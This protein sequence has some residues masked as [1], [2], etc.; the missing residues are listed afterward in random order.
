[1]KRFDLGKMFS[2]IAGI[3]ALS[4]V[5]AASASGG[6]GHELDVGE[7]LRNVF[8][9][10]VNFL[11]FVGLLVYLLRRPLADFLGNRRL[12]ISQQ[13]AESRTAKEDAE[14]SYSDLQTRIAAF[15]GELEAMLVKVRAECEVE[16]ERAVASAH[17]AAEA[18]KQAAQ[19]T[20]VKE[21]EKA[22][23]ELRE[24]TIER[25]M[26]VAE[27]V[28]RAAVGLDDHRRLTA[29]YFERIAKDAKP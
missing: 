8:I 17:Q 20:T 11:L 23:Y 6:G 27:D 16:R 4:L 2:V 29:Q 3:V 28:L 15:D 13:M 7:A 21:L 25:A 5:T 22:R 26:T 18:L 1:V 10:L 14:S 24:W 12:T 9:H 19:R